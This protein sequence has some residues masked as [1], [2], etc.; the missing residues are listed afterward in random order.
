HIEVAEDARTA[1][2]FLRTG[3]SKIEPSARLSLVGSM[4]TG[5]GIYRKAARDIEVVGVKAKTHSPEGNTPLHVFGLSLDCARSLPAR[6]LRPRS[7]AFPSTR[8]RR[9]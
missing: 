5:D 3:G 4:K 1:H 6:L 2:V 9:R 7:H 8:N